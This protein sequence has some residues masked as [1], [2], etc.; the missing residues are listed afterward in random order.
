MRLQNSG[1]VKNVVVFTKWVS[2]NGKM[3]V[4]AQKASDTFDAKVNGKTVKVYANKSKTGVQY[5]YAEIG[6]EWTWSRDAVK[7]DATY[8][9][10]VKATKVEKKAPEVT[11]PSTTPAI[12]TPT[13]PKIIRKNAK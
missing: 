1:D 13:T 8:T 2:G 12:T 9:S 5:F 10:V 7:K 4:Q 6:S 11:V 3:P